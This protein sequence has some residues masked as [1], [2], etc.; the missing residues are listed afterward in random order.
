M[1]ADSSALRPV[2]PFVFDPSLTVATDGDP[3]EA[4]IRP[5][6]RR[7]GRWRSWL[8]GLVSILLL[9]SVLWQLRSAGTAEIGAMLRRSPGFW[10]TFVALYFAQPVAELVIF[11]RLW[12]LPLSGFGA[13]LRKFVSNEIILGYSGEVYFYLWARDRVRMTNAPF[14]AIKDVSITSALMGNVVTLAMLALAIPALRSGDLGA[15]SMPTLWSGLVVVAVSLAIVLFGKRIFSLKRS[16]LVFVSGVHLTRL[17]W[18]TLLTGLLW[19]L[20]LPGV[21]LGVWIILA[22]LRLLVGRL[23]FITNKD[24]VFA[25]VAIFLIGR[26][27][28]VSALMAAVAVLTL[29]AHLVMILLLAGGDVI[30]AARRA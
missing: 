19:H 13:L 26:Q 24:L 18:A 20:A 14:G 17:I 11:R 6:A 30:K 16:D 21:G 4:A 12:K 5:L 28:E 15:Y 29:S 3:I 27:T 22:A 7:G 23:P 25:N 8:A 2:Q 10:V 1:P 9:G